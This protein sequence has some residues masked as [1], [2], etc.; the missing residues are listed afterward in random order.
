MMEPFILIRRRVMDCQRVLTEPEAWMVAVDANLIKCVAKA[1]S[2]ILSGTLPRHGFIDPGNV[3]EPRPPVEDPVRTESPETAKE[4]IGKVCEV[5]RLAGRFRELALR[6]YKS[7][8]EMI[9]TGM[10]RLSTC[11]DSFIRAVFARAQT[12]TP[13]IVP[14]QGHQAPVGSPLGSPVSSGPRVST[15]DH[16]DPQEE[17]TM[18][19]PRD[20]V[21]L[22]TELLQ[23]QYTASLGTPMDTAQ[24]RVEATQGDPPPQLH[25]SGVKV[26]VLR[27]G[28]VLRIPSC[29]R[30]T[31]VPAI[32]GRIWK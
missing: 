2:M 4:R 17:V 20:Q 5:F 3:E 22:L 8:Q 18:T 26:S 31:H 28:H 15:E 14:G 21:R 6:N 25:P 11:E 29:T 9:E 7:Y 24:P 13:D 12:L 27:S 32:G 23:R 1:H 19:I 30:V 10:F 16:Q